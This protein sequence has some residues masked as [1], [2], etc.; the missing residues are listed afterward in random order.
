M[1]NQ[2]HIDLVSLIQTDVHLK[3]VAGTSG[4]EWAGA[5]PFCNDG[6]DRFRVWPNHPISPRWWCRVCNRHGDGIGYLMQ[7]HGIS[8]ADA[9]TRLS[10]T[11]PDV[12]P[13]PRPAPLIGTVNLDKSFML[14]EWQTAAA[15]FVD[16]CY[17]Q[18]QDD[19]DTSAAA[20]Y[21]EGRGI[22]RQM[23]NAKRLGLNRAPTR[24]RWADVTVWLPR[25]IVIPWYDV[26]SPLLWNVRVRRPDA[27]LKTGEA[28]YISPKGIGNGCYNL[29]SVRPGDRVVLVEGE[30]DALIAEQYGQPDSCDVSAVATGG[31]MSGRSMR[32]A[33]KIA[34]MASRV[35]LAFDDDDAG[36]AAAQWWSST[37][38][39]A[40]RVVPAAHDITDMWKRR[41][42]I[43]AWIEG[44]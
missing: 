33:S 7:A 13:A 11:L 18:L 40:V 39:Q 35:L 29:A 1:I 43:A 31:A 32:W 26:S 41:I 10:V 14:D 34:S 4:G 3:R 44:A 24:A 9:C 38:P 17:E 2:K 25:G 21:L 30:F 16:R 20:R 37:I 5:C 42:D 19:W 8:F 28:K 6:S 12:R 23:A 27:D 22:T 36:R 15:R